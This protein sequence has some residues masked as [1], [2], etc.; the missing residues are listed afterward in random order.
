MMAI[1]RNDDRLKSYHHFKIVELKYE[2]Q[3]DKV[4]SKKIAVNKY[5]LQVGISFVSSFQCWF[6]VKVTLLENTR[7]DLAEGK[8]SPC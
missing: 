2:V 8:M 1:G 6:E 3:E 5:F 7:G 4:Y